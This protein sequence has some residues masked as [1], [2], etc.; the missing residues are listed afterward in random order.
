MAQEYITLSEDAL[1][2]LCSLIKA[3]GG[4]VDIIDDKNV[5]TNSVYSSAKITELFDNI[6]TA[7]GAGGKGISS[8]EFESSSLG[9]EVGQAGATDTY[10]INYSD[11]T[12][13]TFK[14]YNGQDGTKGTRILSIRTNPS[15]GS[16]TLPDGTDYFYKIRLT[17]VQSQAN[18]T[19]VYVEDL[20]L[21]KAILYQVVGMDEEYVYMN[22][23][24][25]IKGD[26]PTIG[27]NGNWWINGTDTGVSAGG[28]SDIK[29]IV[30][31]GVI[32]KENY[33]LAYS[34][35]ANITSGQS[36]SLI[37][38]IDGFLMINNGNYI[39]IRSKENP[40]EPLYQLNVTLAGA[41]IQ[42][43][44][45][46][47]IIPSP[48]YRRQNNHTVLVYFI[49][50]IANGSLYG[51]Q[52]NLDQSIQS[53]DWNVQLAKITDTAKPTVFSLTQSK[54][55]VYCILDGNDI[56]AFPNG[57]SPVIPINVI[58]DS[59]PMEEVS[60]EA[61]KC[62]SDGTVLGWWGR[63]GWC[64]MTERVEQDGVHWY[65]IGFMERE[66]V[67]NDEYMTRNIYDIYDIFKWKDYII[68]CGSE[69]WYYCHESALVGTDY[70]EDNNLTCVPC[71]KLTCLQDTTF[72]MNI[73]TN[74]RIIVT[75]SQNGTYIYSSPFESNAVKVNYNYQSIPTDLF[76]NGGIRG[77]IET[78]ECIYIIGQDQIKVPYYTYEVSLK[79]AI[80]KL[81]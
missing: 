53:G 40:E 11:N 30:N 65:P 28:S 3:G 70:L 71:T 24:T 41:P 77:L 75:N 73:A 8:I 20:L 74:G 49:Y 14:V 10:K 60:I 45:D 26:T 38:A 61:I 78:T 29:V 55:K 42:E 54:D 12:S 43:I 16:G 56:I 36:F 9:G 79:E 80:N 2:R 64:Y 31:D 32:V 66:R 69:G 48:S 18:V 25:S 34:D 7:G 59:I 13:S 72:P 58:I 4:G 68:C 5:A 81:K 51:G 21:N 50:V 47:A 62:M 37:K 63:T 17:S 19:D 15:T 46:F 23:I 52:F 76:V 27:D 1:S 33:N 57:S 6:K 67:A 44:I 22:N 39:S 35:H